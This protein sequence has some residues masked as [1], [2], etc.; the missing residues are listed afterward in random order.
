LT[1][2]CGHHI[3]A[4]NFRV[5]QSQTRVTL[6]MFSRSPSQAQG[7]TAQRCF[8]ELSRHMK[9]KSL[10]AKAE[11][12][13]FQ[14]GGRQAMTDLLQQQKQLTLIVLVNEERGTGG[15]GRKNPRES[16]KVKMLG[17]ERDFCSPF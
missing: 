3:K 8:F 11:S 10:T 17:R 6:G 15:R 14:Q 4:E 2:F 9:K 7:A 1:P 12:Q 13:H 5:R 16:F